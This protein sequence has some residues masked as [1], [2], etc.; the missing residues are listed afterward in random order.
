MYYAIY[1]LELCDFVSVRC[2][3]RRMRSTTRN[4]RCDC[5]CVCVTV[6]LKDNHETKNG[7][8]VLS[9]RIFEDNL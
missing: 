6:A 9:N 1:I 5:V 4:V 3:D 2:S 8:A 7:T